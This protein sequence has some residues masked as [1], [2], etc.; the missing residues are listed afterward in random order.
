MTLLVEEFGVE[1][2][3]NDQGTPIFPV[4]KTMSLPPH[5]I[6]EIKYLLVPGE[7]DLESGPIFSVH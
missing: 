1:Y 5:I 4:F 3:E 2:P 6:D 7:A